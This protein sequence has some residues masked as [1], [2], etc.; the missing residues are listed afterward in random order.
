MCTKTALLVILFLFKILVFLIPLGIYV[1][2]RTS[3]LD[4]II[5][6]L[7]IGEVV[8]LILLI[9]L[10]VFSSD[11]IKNSTINGIKLNSMIF[12]N[13]EFV[14]EETTNIDYKNINPTKVYKNN[15]NMDV[16]YYNINYYPLKDIKINC[17]KK[18]YFKNYGNDIAALST[19]ISTITGNAVNPYD[20]LEYALKTGILTCDNIPTSEELITAITNLYGIN[21]SR[22]SSNELMNNLNS[23]K[24]V[25]AK[26]KVNDSNENI[27]CNEKLIVIYYFNSKGEFSIINPSDTLYDYFCSN[28]TV[29]YGSI[30]KGNQNKSVFSKEELDNYITD[31][32]VL[33]AD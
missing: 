11:C 13:I 27:S 17:E 24:M 20:I 22:I 19:A 2:K 18:S 32:Y 10:S 30:V 28:N 23:G 29:G 14:K 5:K 3:A 8:I 6:Y 16:N 31:Y 9:T 26:T 4:K 21:V 1:L 12:S 7:Y 25:L 33:G 15:V